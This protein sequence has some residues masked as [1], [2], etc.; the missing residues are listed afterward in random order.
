MK[1]TDCRRAARTWLIAI[2]LLLSLRFGEGRLSAQHS[3]FAT[4]DSRHDFVHWIEL[5]SADGSLID[6]RQS[7]APYSPR[8]T[9]GKCHDYDT[10]SQGHHFYPGNGRPHDGDAGDNQPGERHSNDHAQV[11][12]RPGEPLFWV[13][14]KTGTQIPLSFRGWPGTY[15]PDDLRLGHWELTLRFGRYLP[16]GGFAE[17]SL[18]G[19]G[20]IPNGAWKFS[21]DDETP[22]G[23]W[24]L[25]GKLEIDCLICHTRDR[26]Y[27]ANARGDQIEQQNFA[28]AAT[29]AAG[30]GTVSGSV[31]AL[32]DSFD[33][34]AEKSDSGDTER[35]PEVAYR[36]ERFRRD[37]KVFIDITRTP[38]SNRCYFC[39]STRTIGS[40]ADRGP[41]YDH[42]LLP[43]EDIHLT[44]GLS[45]ADCHRNGLEHRTV[46]GF[47]G[48]RHPAGK[49]VAALSCRGCHVGAENSSVP[50][51]MLGAPQARHPGL[52]PIHFERLA[53]TACHSGPYP[54]ETAELMQTAQAH[55]LGLPAHRTADDPPQIVGPVFRADQ[56]GVIA[57][58]RVVWPSFWGVLQKGEIR[59]IHPDVAY[60]T[61][62][63]TLRV[64]RNF[65]RE[66]GDAFEEKLT[67]AFEALSKKDLGG[68]PVF[69]SGGRVYLT[70]D[71]LKQIDHRAAE[72]YAWPI[73]HEVRPASLAL[74]ARGCTECHAEGAPVFA[75]RVVARGQAPDPHPKTSAMREWERLDAARLRLWSRSF[76]LRPL[77]KWF[78]FG[79]LAVV[80]LALL[81]WWPLAGQPYPSSDSP[82]SRRLGVAVMVAGLTLVA[83]GILT[84]TGLVGWLGAGHL[85]GLGLLI[86]MVG[87]GLFLTCLG[88]W[89]VT[90]ARRARKGVPLWPG[91]GAWQNAPA[92]LGMVLFL[93]GGW[94][95]AATMLVSML[96]WFDTPELRNLLVIHR[97]SGLAAVGGFL[98]FVAA[99]L[100]LRLG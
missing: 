5:R 19:D 73:A 97:A 99:R 42:G 15:H 37:G 14:V 93:V 2:V 55:Q 21:D 11:A 49:E 39:H 70:G 92:K 58:Y 75:G 76:T 82:S 34:D 38:D 46:R 74:G 81:R 40:H 48:E 29:V 90:G 66:I 8:A 69:V 13:D 51:G 27:D 61:L 12:D 17:P 89:A 85:G 94:L 24:K 31:K 65:R 1:A 43:H 63:R 67:K 33:P 4:A 53:C 59:P 60:K 45:C 95:A 71:P 87:S 16:G 50:R 26:S 86:H 47:P 84:T 83:L 3:R 30:L 22:S 80:A 56:N 36:V 52:P 10:I 72:P 100:A 64:R 41:N 32:P 88:Y 28:W 68:T 6:P 77:F 98:L 25:S 91:T 79:V 23:R 20:E 35:L 54:R 62:R 18:D 78:G 44:A 96:H 57:P 7:T 9:C